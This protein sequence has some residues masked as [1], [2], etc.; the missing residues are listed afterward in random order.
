MF[1]NAIRS[2]EESC[3]D[4]TRKVSNEKERKKIKIL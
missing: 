4:R 3:Y 2:I 1:G